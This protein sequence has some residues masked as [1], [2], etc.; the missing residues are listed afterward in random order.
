VYCGAIG[1]VGPSDAHVRARFNVAIRTAVIDSHSGRAVHGV[2][3][4]ITW[5]SE[6]AAEHLEVLA[7]TA[8]L[9][10]RQR[11]F[12]LIETMRYDSERGLRN[13]DRHLRRL[14]DGT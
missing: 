10:R 4:G 5:S 9:G 6:A 8:I 1:F 14:A 12:E 11:D 7:K 3:G 2:G 13:R